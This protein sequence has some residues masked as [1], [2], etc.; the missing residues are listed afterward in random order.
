MQR[1]RR[2]KLERLGGKAEIQAK[3]DRREQHPA[4]LRDEQQRERRIAR[5]EARQRMEET[6]NRE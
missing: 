5:F 4:I 1:S 6:M 2:R 3:I